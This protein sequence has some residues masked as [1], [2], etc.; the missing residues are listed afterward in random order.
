RELHQSLCDHPLVS[1][2]SHT[3]WQLTLTAHINT[4]MHIL[5]RAY[6]QDTQAL[7][8]RSWLFTIREHLHLFDQ[9]EFRRRLKDNPFVESLAPAPRK[10][11]QALLEEDI[12][13]CSPK[14]PLVK[15]LWI[16][17]KSHV[18]HTEAK[19]MIAK[20]NP[21]DAYPL[22]VGNFEALLA[23][24]KAILNRY[25]S[26]FMAMTYEMQISGH[27]DYQC[28]F[29]CVEEK[30]QRNEE[31]MKHLEEEINARGRVKHGDVST[32]PRENQ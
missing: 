17:R 6:D 14:D 29:T 2:Q 26:L 13:L 25:S 9:E 22:T 8:L 16:H 18:A 23:R 1:S 3:F 21:H 4:C 32:E 31:A 20:R 24:A 15:T 10:P 28:I 19:N 5:C 30:I 12:R 7:H 27:D 11:D